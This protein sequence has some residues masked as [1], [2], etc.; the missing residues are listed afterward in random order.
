MRSVDPVL[1]P[2]Q[3]RE[4]GDPARRR[5][6]DG[7]GVVFRRRAGSRLGFGGFGGVGGGAGEVVLGDA[8][9]EVD[10]EGVVAHPTYLVSWMTAR[11]VG[12][13]SIG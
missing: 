4:G 5:L 11:L 8:A 10:Y 7:P 9:E 2:V 6:G 1:P 12:R 3:P 13:T